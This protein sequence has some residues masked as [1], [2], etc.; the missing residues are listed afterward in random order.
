MFGQTQPNYYRTKNTKNKIGVRF[1]HNY[2]FGPIFL[3]I[4]CIRKLVELVKIDA[5][6][7]ILLF[8][9]LNYCTALTNLIKASTTTTNNFLE[10][11]LGLEIENYENLNKILAS[12]FGGIVVETLITST[13]LSPLLLNNHESTA[14]IPSPSTS[15]IITIAKNNSLLIKVPKPSTLSLFSIISPANVNEIFNLI[16][17]PTSTDLHLEGL[18]IMDT[19]TNIPPQTIHPL[20]EA[21]NTQPW[22]QPFTLITT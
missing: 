3:R 13:I 12:E 4:F 9:P 20:L 15:T 10:L 21:N 19:I 16:Q 14:T 2:F 11:S 5:I 17:M 7:S 6:N 8:A 22:L 18:V 1:L